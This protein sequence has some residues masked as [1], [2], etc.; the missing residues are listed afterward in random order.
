VV[1]LLVASLAGT[2]VPLLMERAGVDPALAS[3][4]FVTTVTDVT[5]F[6]AFLGLA[7]WLLL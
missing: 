5:G 3:G 7:T 4:T 2:F 6:C 1:N